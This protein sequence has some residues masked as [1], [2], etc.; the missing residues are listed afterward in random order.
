MIY[1]IEYNRTLGTVTRMRSFPD[2][3]RKCAEDERLQVELRRN[4]ARENV[5]VV[6]LEAPSEAALRKTHRRYFEDIVQLVQSSA[7]STG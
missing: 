2:A 6:L 4:Q 1:L 7:T 5:E 3:E